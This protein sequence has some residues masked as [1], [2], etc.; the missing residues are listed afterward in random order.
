VWDGRAWRVT[1]DPAGGA[2]PDDVALSAVDCPEPGLCV[3]VGHLTLQ[4]YGAPDEVRPVVRIGDGTRWADIDTAALGVD[5]NRRLDHVSCAGPD[6]CLALGPDLSLAG[7]RSGWRR[8]PPVARPTDV[9]CLAPDR[10]LAADAGDRGARLL[11][12]DGTSWKPAPDAFGPVALDCVGREGCV[13]FGYG[14]GTGAPAPTMLH[15][16]GTAFVPTRLDGVPPVGALSCSALDH[17][18]ILDERGPSPHSWLFDGAAWRAGA[19]PSFPVG[20]PP[21]QERHTG[22]GL[23]CIPGECHHVGSAPAG[24]DI[25]PAAERLAFRPRGPAGTRPV[26]SSTTSPFTS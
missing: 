11:V 6:D 20:T 7:G 1:T 25:A 8:I 13:A 12:W 15:W 16:D 10:C 2:P 23:A 9:A 18:V 3:A 22:E 14:E 5:G 24:S 17:C 26:A 4:T 19:V 21:D